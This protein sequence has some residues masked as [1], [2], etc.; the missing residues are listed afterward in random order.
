[1]SYRSQTWSHS[2]I[3]TFAQLKT[4]FPST[5]IQQCVEI[6]EATEDLPELGNR[7]EYL[8][9]RAKLNLLPTYLC[10]LSVNMEQL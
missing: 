8:T 5:F 2:L 1:M 4:Q 10:K 3:Y 7:E 6:D 9:P